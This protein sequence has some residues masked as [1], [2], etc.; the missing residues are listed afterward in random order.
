M[1]ATTFTH[2]KS[3]YFCHIFIFWD[4]WDNQGLPNCCVTLTYNLWCILTLAST[5]VFQRNR[6]GRCSLPIFVWC[7]ATVSSNQHLISQIDY[8]I[9]LTKNWVAFTAVG[10]FCL[11]QSSTSNFKCS[12]SHILVCSH[13]ALNTVL[14]LPLMLVTSI[15]LT[16]S[17]SYQI[18]ECI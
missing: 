2:L 1:R 12:G 17:I 7:W 5:L 6:Y 15:L 9:Q 16:I 18:F 13:V 11:N 3:T 4:Y 10:Q 8:H 14:M